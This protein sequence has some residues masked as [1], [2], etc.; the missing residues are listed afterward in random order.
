MR[1]TPSR[2][3]CYAS[4]TLPAGCAEFT[5]GWQS[6]D[7]VKGGSTFRFFN[8]HL[9]TEDAAQIQ[10]AQ[11]AI[12]LGVINASPYPVVAVGDYNSAADGSTTA[13]YGNLVKTGKLKDVWSA[14]NG[15]AGFSCCQ[16]EL[17]D[18]S[19]STA[20]SRIDL[21]LT[22]GKIAAKSAALTGD[23]PFATLAP[24]WASDHFGVAA[25]VKT[26]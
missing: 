18:N 9:E 16:E 13:T 19:T 17:L 1:T 26:P 12:A 5:R 21:V 23:T 20:G 4:P 10:E 8:S 24:L 6:V 2:T 25:T 3:S 15:D 7:V 22:K 11:G 14:A